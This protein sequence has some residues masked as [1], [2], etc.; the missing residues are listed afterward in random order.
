MIEQNN[1]ARFRKA[2]PFWASLTFLPMFFL[3]VHIGGW[4]F[5]L[6]PVYGLI[7]F[8]ALDFIGG[9]NLENPDPDSA[10]SALFWYVLVTLIWPV[11]E[12][13]IIFSA[14]WAVANVSPMS[15]WE[16]F[17]LMYGVGLVSGAIGITYAHELMHRPG[18]LER[19]L[20]DVLMALVLYGHFRSEHLLVHH[21]YVATPRDPVTARYN[22]SFLRFFP[23]VLH[24]CLRSAWRTECA[25]L[26][27]SKRTR[28]S[29]ANPFY[30]YATLQSAALAS[31][32]LVAGREGVAF[33]TF[34]AFVAIWYLEMVNYV[35]HYGLTR[36]H[37]GNGKYEPVKPHH[38]WNDAHRA[39][40]WLLINLQRHS[41]HHTKP[42]K[43]FPLLRT[44]DEREAPQ[45]PV[46]YIGMTALSMVP[47][48]WRRVMN[49]R[50][51]AWRAQFYP[52]V[53]DWQ[54][55]K[56]GTNPMPKA[57]E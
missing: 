15:A 48:L 31:A 32:W 41:D 13:I 35:E 8:S 50:V 36:K 10:E 53:D 47:W 39:T 49:P 25:R 28:F 42:G 2:L 55:Y 33:F 57:A 14:L 46:S 20:G 9:Y 44:Y 6:I 19:N 34:Q 3:S 43:R 37:L 21:A 56:M 38:S 16:K 29:L 4:A 12:V 30:K 11:A 1:M 45:L 24:Q 27:R 51:Q 26:E 52:E 18:R 40:N 54:P 17:G 22:E 5:L 7:V 23:R